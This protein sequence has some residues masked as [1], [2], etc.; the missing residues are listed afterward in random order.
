MRA[1]LCRLVCVMAVLGI[2]VGSG[3]AQ[4]TVVG[5]RPGFGDAASLVAPGRVQV[6]VGY[7]Y[8]DLGTSGQHTVG[9][10]VVRVGVVGWVELRAGLNSYV[11]QERGCIAGVICGQARGY[12]K[13]FEDF[14]VGAKV[15]LLQ[16]T[17]PR[18]PVLTV[19][20][21]AALPTG[22]EA[23]TGEVVRPTLKLALDL[24]LN[25]T[26]AFSANVGNTFRLGGNLFEAFF[27]YVA[28]GSS[29]SAV[30][31]LGVFA[32]LYSFFPRGGD[33]ANSLDGGLVYLLN[34]N[35]QLDINL[36]VGLTP[37]AADL[38]VGVGVV[39]RF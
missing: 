20:A 22:A 10:A 9:Q 12:D 5:D 29:V 26:V 32:G 14:T 11:V 7:T 36:G 24:A 4:D 25:E 18:Q 8:A 34:E 38:F 3:A 15:N 1:G 39:Q 33:L 6:E 21:S 23:F 16:G 13:G 27:T 17:T 37:E 19:L 30:E 31:G 2:G 28:L 35:T